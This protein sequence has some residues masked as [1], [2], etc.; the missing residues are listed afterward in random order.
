[1]YKL[2]L[3][4]ST[5]FGTNLGFNLV[6]IITPQYFPSVVTSRIFGICNVFARVATICAPMIAELDEPIPLVIY[7]A[8]SS[9]AALTSLGLRK[10]DDFEDS[11]K[12]RMNNVEKH[13]KDRK[14]QGKINRS[15]M[16]NSNFTQV[17]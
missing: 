2:I 7:V 5:K 3:V 12:D 17:S 6:Y 14:S 8:L 9:S 4:F 10:K 13:N 1:M 15:E 16:T 11:V